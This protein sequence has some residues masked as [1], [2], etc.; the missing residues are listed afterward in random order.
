[1]RNKNASIGQVAK[2]FHKNNNG[3]LGFLNRYNWQ[4]KN[5]NDGG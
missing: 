3:K 4:S 1:M 5:T 2:Y